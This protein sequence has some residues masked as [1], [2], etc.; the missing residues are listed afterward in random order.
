M[1]AQE[2]RIMSEACVM[3]SAEADHVQPEQSVVIAIFEHKHGRDV[4]A[5]ASE[6]GAL[7]WRWEIADRWWEAELDAERPGPE[8]DLGAAYFKRV[9]GEWFSIETVGIHE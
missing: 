5:F 1:L 7:R 2:S 9:S 4:C 3:G 6:A 8:T